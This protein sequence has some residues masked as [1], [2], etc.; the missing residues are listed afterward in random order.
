MTSHREMLLFYLGAVRVLGVS[1]SPARTA[2]RT[3][4]P[5][6]ANADNEDA[7]GEHGDEMARVSHVDSM[8]RSGC[9]IKQ[10]G[11]CG[12]KAQALAGLA[13]T[14]VLRAA[15]PPETLSAPDSQHRRIANEFNAYASTV[16]VEVT[17]VVRRSRVDDLPFTA[18]PYVLASKST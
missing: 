1:S 4:H 11:V 3:H 7:G 16:G 18:T 2:A 12:L 9:G 15:V 6:D 14:R 8:P 13:P 5:E 10:M 17:F